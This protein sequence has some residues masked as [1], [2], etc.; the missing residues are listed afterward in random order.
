M[1]L[2]DIKYASMENFN[3]RALVVTIIMLHVGRDID[4][5]AKITYIPALRNHVHHFQAQPYQR[6]MDPPQPVQTGLL[7]RVVIN[8]SPKPK[9]W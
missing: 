8:A 7:N 9:F 3:V 2:V 6:A 1:S 4:A 5:C